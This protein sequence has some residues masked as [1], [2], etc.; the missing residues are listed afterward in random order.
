MILLFLI[1]SQFYIV[2]LGLVF[3]K[4][5]AFLQSSEERT[6]DKISPYVAMISLTCL[7]MNYKRMKDLFEQAITGKNKSLC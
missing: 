4:P 2:F 3:T 6:F 7:T 5:F 1:L